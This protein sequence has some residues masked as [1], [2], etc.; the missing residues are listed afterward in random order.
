ML[1]A[2]LS[3]LELRYQK[4]YPSSETE[5]NQN[6]LM[7]DNRMLGTGVRM[8]EDSVASGVGAEEFY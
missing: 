4:E 3:E 2:Y 7:Q 5:Q 6:S 8:P 1:Q